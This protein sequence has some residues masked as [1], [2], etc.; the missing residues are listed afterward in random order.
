MPNIAKVLKDEISRIS[1]KEAKAAV[2]PVRK[3][4]GM[5]RRTLADLKRRVAALEKETARLIAVLGKVQSAQPEAAAPE[6]AGRAR[7]TSKGMKSL[8][9]KLG[10]SQRDF[11]RLLG[12]TTQAI[13]LWE[14]K[15][16]ALRLRGTTKAAVLAI[17][18]VG[19][20]EA[21][22]RLEEMAAKAKVKKARR[23]G[24]KGRK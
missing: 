23:K 1:R 21:R 8:R 13:Y 4:S 15:S 7:I 14:R 24:R 3:P 6:A 9:R 22:Q 12:I 11:A 5:T 20:K 17:R 16:G 2:A 10:L 18:A 19:A